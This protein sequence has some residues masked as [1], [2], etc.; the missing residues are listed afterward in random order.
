MFQEDK[1][2]LE[3]HIRKEIEDLKNKIIFYKEGAKPV[4]L[5]SAIGRVTRMDAI[6]CKNMSE[7]SLRKAEN[8]LLQL[9]RALDKIGD[10]DF[11][12][13]VKCGEEIS[14]KRLMIMPGSVL[15]VVCALVQNR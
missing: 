8:T 14:F 3:K 6:N 5:D 13:C 9:E 4:A 10:S 15:C 1:E 7:A 12:L 11:G 2:R